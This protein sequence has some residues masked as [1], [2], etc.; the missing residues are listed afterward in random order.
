MQIDLYD[1]SF[2]AFLSA[3]FDHPAPAEGEDANKWYWDSDAEFVVDPARQVAH[4]TRLFQ[5]SAALG[6]RFSRAQLEQGFWLIAGAASEYFVEHLWNSAVPWQERAAC[7]EAM[8]RLYADCLATGG[9]ETIDYMWSGLIADPYDYGVRAPAENP[10]DA[11]MQQAL[12]ELFDRLLRHPEPICHYAALHG[13][14]HLRHP[15]GPRAIADYLARHPELTPEQRQ[16]AE[17]A[18]AGDVL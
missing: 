11:R 6:K 9:F 2:D 8:E 4:L 7:V 12:L 1:A 16:Y 15:D 17:N 5:E 13:L 3:V 18:M 14:G 10:E